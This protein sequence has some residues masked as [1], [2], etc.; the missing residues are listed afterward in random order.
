MEKGGVGLQIPDYLQKSKTFLLVVIDFDGNY[1]FG[2]ELFQQKYSSIDKDFIGKPFQLTVHP[3]DFE[4][5][6]QAAFRCF[7]NE[8]FSTVCVRKP[9]PSGDVFLW[10]QWE[11]SIFKGADGNPVGILCV[12]FD[13]TEAEKAAIQ[14][15]EF[16]EKVETI[17]NEIP[18]AYFQ[19]DANLRVIEANNLAREQFGKIGTQVLGSSIGSI[20]VG[21]SDNSEVVKLKKV[22]EEKRFASF[23]YLNKSLCTWYQASAYPSGEGL[24]VFLRDIS[25]DKRRCEELEESK[26]ELDSTSRKLESILNG[27]SDVVWSISLPERKMLFVTPSVQVMFGLSVDESMA[28]SGWLEKRIFDEDKEVVPALFN[29]VQKVGQFEEEF[30]VID[31]KG[32]IRWV[33]CRATKIADGSGRAVR[34]DG[35]IRDVTDKVLAKKQLEKARDFLAH[36]NKVAKVGGWEFNRLTKEG[37]WS[38]MVCCIHEM[39]PGFSPSIEEALRFYVP[40]SKSVLEHAL[41]ATFETGRS[42]DL[43]LQLRT[44]KGNLIWVRAIGN[45][46][47][48]N[49]EITGLFGTLQDISEPKRNEEYRKALLASIPDLLFVLDSEGVFLDFKAEINDLHTDPSL[50][51]NRKTTEILPFDIATRLLNSIKLALSKRSP[52]ELE[53][54]LEVN[55]KERFYQARISPLGTDKVIAVSRELTEIREKELKLSESEQK[56]QRTIEAIPH[57]FLILSGDFIVHDTNWDFERVFGYSKEEVV[58]KPIDFL[59]PETYRKDG[60]SVLSSCLPGPPNFEIE[61]FLPVLT[62]FGTEVFLSISS[63]SFI[64]GGTVWIIAVLQDV[65]KLV[66]TQERI[67]E[68]NET[69][70]EIAWQQSHELRRHVANILGLADLLKNVTSEP[71]EERQELIDYIILSANQIDEV[72]H[73]IVHQATKGRF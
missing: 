34:I 40:E 11:F 28:D 8:E 24:T 42:F 41:K 22:L 65:T 12:G 71:D 33:S 52:T 72:I 3:D 46:T 49:Q 56:L 21:S 48:D 29:S 10:T 45:A 9:G 36:T 23:E 19:L 64:S 69:L 60:T 62:K 37:F 51:L 53:Y 61:G 16:A 70:R 2:N 38:D 5:C 4:K 26:R 30:R 47:Y 59:I 7:T 15:K 68:H 32:L 13:I 6:K 43:E 58:G 57:P 20:L 25:Q 1:L 66:K 18:D 44:A 55:G 50:F 54:L 73:K 39:P 27:M 63:S 35:I 14:V 31:G 17:L 67:L